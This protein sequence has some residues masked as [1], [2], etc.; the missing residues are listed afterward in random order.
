MKT[1]LILAS[2]SPHRARLLDEAGIKY[3]QKTSTI[4]E[5]EI[6]KAFNHNNVSK[7]Y[8]KKICPNT[9]PRENRTVRLVIARRALPDEAIANG[10]TRNHHRRHRNLVPWA[11]T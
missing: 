5:A 11:H 4:D 2:S 6:Q 3:I 7:R 9:R 10:P 8:A 1:T